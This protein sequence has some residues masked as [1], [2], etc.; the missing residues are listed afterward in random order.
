MKRSEFV[1]F[2][3]LMSIL[4]LASFW[5]AKNRMESFQLG[6]EIA[7][8]E[9]EKDKLLEE[10]RSLQAKRIALQS[11]IALIKK[12]EELQLDL[13]PPEDWLELPKEP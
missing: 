3:T 13:V 10:G 4:L 6:Y 11:P 7:Q 5:I 9:K 12:N 1:T 8:L 2:A